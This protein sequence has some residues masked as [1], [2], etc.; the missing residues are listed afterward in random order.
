MTPMEIRRAFNDMLKAGGWTKC[1]GDSG[2]VFSMD[3]RQMARR[4]ARI[5]F[6]LVPD[7]RY[8]ANVTYEAFVKAPEFRDLVERLGIRCA[9]EETSLDG[10]VVRLCVQINF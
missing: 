9:R 1:Y 10:G 2:L 8:D 3:R 6:G 4:S 7:E 5:E